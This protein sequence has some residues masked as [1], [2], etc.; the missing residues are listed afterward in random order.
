MPVDIMW[1]AGASSLV[2]LIT[3]ILSSIDNSIMIVDDVKMRVLI[4]TQ[5][6]SDKTRARLN[7]IADKR[8]RHMTAM[9]VFM[10]F[11]GVISSAYLGAMAINMLTS[12]GFIVYMLLLT[13][14]NLVLS[15][16]FPKVIAR[17]HYERILIRSAFITRV[18]YFV[19]MPMVLLTLMW[20]KIFRLDKQRKMSIQDLKCTID[21]YQSKGLI[22]QTEASMLENIF[23]VKQHSIEELL[24]PANLPRVNKDTPLSECREI[25]I[26]HSGNRIIVTENNEITGIMYYRDLVSKLFAEDQGTVADLW[27]PAITVKG[28]ESLLEIMIRMKSQKVGQVVVID[29]ENEVRGVV[30]AKEIYSHIITNSAEIPLTRIK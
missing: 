30:T 24:V 11:I 16:T 21:F 27:R 9:V 10:T 15:R 19:A 7:K 29:D 26:K 22:E 28:S 23:R 4:E 3:A 6:M 14:G 18:I 17:S 13:Y 8:D 5:E 20:V 12:T 25:A 2:I 1:L